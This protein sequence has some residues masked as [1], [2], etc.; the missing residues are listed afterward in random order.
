MANERNW[1]TSV[2]R[3]PNAEP[4]SRRA[5][6]AVRDRRGECE[7]CQEALSQKPERSTGMTETDLPCIYQHAHVQDTQG[8]K[9]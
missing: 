1:A 4:V 6:D 5:V 9:A 8:A 7:H 2:S 3:V